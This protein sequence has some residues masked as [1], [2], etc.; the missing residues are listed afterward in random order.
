MVPYSF[1]DFGNAETRDQTNPLRYSDGKAVYYSAPPSTAIAN[2]VPDHYTPSG[3]PQTPGTQVFGT[4]KSWSEM[5]EPIDN[6]HREIA[7]HISEPFLYRSGLQAAQRQSPN[8]RY[9]AKSN[10][11]PDNNSARF[12]DGRYRGDIY[13]G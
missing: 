8:V 7:L 9:F 2:T 1:P 10:T 13:G 6:S 4:G 5:P 11:A 12:L 3:I